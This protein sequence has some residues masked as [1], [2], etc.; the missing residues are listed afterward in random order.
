MKVC[1]KWVQ[2]MVDDGLKMLEKMKV[3]VRKSLQKFSPLLK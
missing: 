2:R 3:L 1:E